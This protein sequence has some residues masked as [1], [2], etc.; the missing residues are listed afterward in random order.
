MLA[1]F[2]STGYTG[3]VLSVLLG[4]IRTHRGNVD[5]LLDNVAAEVL[6][7]QCPVVLE[8]ADHQAPQL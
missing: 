4:L 2:M 6:D 8:E 1:E 5:G 7:L 3:P